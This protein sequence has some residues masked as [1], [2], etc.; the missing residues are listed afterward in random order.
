[1]HQHAAIASSSLSI[2]LYSS[3]PL[4][5]SIYCSPLQADADRHAPAFEDKVCKSKGRVYCAKASSGWRSGREGIGIEGKGGHLI[6]A[7]SHEARAWEDRQE[8]LAKECLACS[9]ALILPLDILYFFSLSRSSQC[10]VLANAL[11]QPFAVE[12]ADD[13]WFDVNDPKTT[14]LNCPQ[15]E[16]SKMF[17]WSMH[18][19][20]NIHSIWHSRQLT[21]QQTI[22]NWHVF[23]RH[24]GMSA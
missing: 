10:V 11:Q 16:E 24:L 15:R 19:V 9:F 1:M 23:H 3:E 13:E 7:E 18:D 8:W 5:S 14:R 6:P 22:H 4:Y 17:Y 12:Q 21:T 2:I 20:C